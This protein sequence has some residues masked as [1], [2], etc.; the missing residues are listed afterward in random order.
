MPSK[1][2]CALDIGSS[3]VSA[4][5]AAF[6]GKELGEV[7]VDC[8][9]SDGIKNGV[10][11]DSS[12]LV[13]SVTCLLKSLK[14]KSGIKIKF[15]SCAVSGQDI[16]TRHSRAI[17]PLAQRGSKIITSA[18]VQRINEQ[19]RILGLSLDE[20]II[21]EIPLSY[22][23]DSK[24]DIKNPLGLYSHKLQ[25]DL[26]LVCARHAFVQGLNRAISQSGYEIRDLFFSGL[27][28]SKAVF[29]RELRDGLN[30]FLD[31]GADITELSVFRDGLLVDIEILN[32]GG[33][34]LTRQLQ[35]H[36]KLPF[37]LSEDIKRTYAAIGEP[38]QIEESKEILVKKLNL[39]KPIKQRLVSELITS[40]AKSIC[41]D[42][43]K[44][45]DSKIIGCQINNF[46]AA[47]RTVI[48]EGFIEM[49]ESTL[50]CPVKLARI[51]N[52]KIL[53]CVK[54]N[55]DL[56]GSKYLSYLSCLGIIST[57]LHEDKAEFPSFRNPSRKNL[58]RKILSRFKEVYEEY[59]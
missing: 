35:D 28:V 25:V 11:T 2:I 50:S 58:F 18:D 30:I 20:E 19:A 21:H 13:K 51:N 16:V 24:S 10:I 57:L 54:G 48:L 9:P 26:Y 43:K 44:A 6:R 12:A 40:R 42:I 37:D 29:D 7:F 22:A 8:L 46:F 33:H 31:V 4:A 34:D 41:L 38:S 27:A 45:V 47:G 3:K 49:L 1:Y 55:S 56:S 39:Y 14:V 15:L 52:K 32:I 17:L 23:I 53:S 59:F 36:L 5:V